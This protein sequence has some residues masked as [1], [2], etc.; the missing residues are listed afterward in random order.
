MP[1]NCLVNFWTVMFK[2]SIH[3]Q[4]VNN[5]WTLMFQK[6]G[7]FAFRLSPSVSSS[8]FL[9]LPLSS[10]LFLSS[11]SLSLFV[12][13]SFCLFVSLSLPLLS[14]LFHSFPLSSSL[15]LSFPLLLSFFNVRPANTANS[16]KTKELRKRH[17]W[18]K[19]LSQGK[20]LK[21]KT[22]CA[23]FAQWFVH[24]PADPTLHTPPKLPLHTPPRNPTLCR[25]S[26]R[27]CRPNPT[28]PTP[29]IITL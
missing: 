25:L 18:L 24:F 20:P 13:L 17:F 6:D 28:H 4:F 22:L 3:G 21:L 2:K 1:I 23:K 9:S 26:C 12:F 19:F 10:S 29:L 15:F 8:P 11:S 5:S 14:S 27:I 7:P 16:L